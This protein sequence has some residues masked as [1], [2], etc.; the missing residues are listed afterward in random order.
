MLDFQFL[1]PLDN[2]LEVVRP[3]K[4]YAIFDIISVENNTPDDLANALIAKSI[5]KEDKFFIF[6]HYLFLKDYQDQCMYT[7]EF[8]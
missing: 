5:P 1:K 3:A 6:D 2:Y 4:V 7:A 8:Y